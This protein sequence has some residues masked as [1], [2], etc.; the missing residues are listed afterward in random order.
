MVKGLRVTGIS[1]K[2][3]GRETRDKKKVMGGIIGKMNYMLGKK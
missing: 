3:L 1:G 2:K